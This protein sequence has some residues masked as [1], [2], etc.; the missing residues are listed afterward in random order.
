MLRGDGDVAGAVLSATTGSRIDL[1]VG[2]GGAPEGVIAA[3]A[4]K[5]L[6]GGMLMRLAPQSE[7]ERT[8]IAAAGLDARRILTAEEVIASDEIFIA[9]TGISDGPLLP[10]VRYQGERAE[11]HSLILRCAT[12][13]RRTVVAEHVLEV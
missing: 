13:T 11:T 8:A 1:L 4:V 3:C 12:G 5:A 6:R 2:I 10:G 7:A 9:A